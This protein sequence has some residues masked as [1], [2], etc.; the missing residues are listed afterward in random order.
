MGKLYIKAVKT[1]LEI[2]E[3]EKIK[4]QQKTETK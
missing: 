3:E 2:E 4:Q 1:Y